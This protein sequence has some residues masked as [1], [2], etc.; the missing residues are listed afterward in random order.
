MARFE[1]TSL[2]SL[3]A[4]ARAGIIASELFFELLVTV[5]DSHS[6]FN[7]RLRREAASP[8]T[9]RLERS[10]FRRVRVR[11]ASFRSRWKGSSRFSKCSR[12]ESNLVF[13]LRRV[14]CCPAHSENRGLN[15][16]PSNPPRNR[17]W[18]D[19]FEDCHAIQHTRESY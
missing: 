11:I 5:N 14:A 15:K 2:E 3:A 10:E 17:T 6:A 18:S 4:A 9:H 8:F 13:D 19:S 1:T 16:E 12:Q 7:L